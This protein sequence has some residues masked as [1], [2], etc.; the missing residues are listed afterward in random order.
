[1]A[2][3]RIDDRLQE[4]RRA[5]IEE[6]KKKKLRRVTEG[7]RSSSTRIETTTMSK[8][9]PVASPRF[10]LLMRFY[11]TLRRGLGTIRTERPYCGARMPMITT[12]PLSSITYA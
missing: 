3:S 7:K 6:K 1:M 5:A 11:P 8:M 10:N 4:M 9:P 12:T 2:T